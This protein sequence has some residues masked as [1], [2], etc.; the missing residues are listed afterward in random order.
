MRFTLRVKYGNSTLAEDTPV[1][2]TL[3][4]IRATDADDPG[5]GSSLIQFLITAG[6]ENEVFRVES[7][8]TGVGHVVLAKVQNTKIHSDQ[9]SSNISEV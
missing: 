8:D 7:D 4:T 6:N 2:H 5:S 1:G 3:L 9:N